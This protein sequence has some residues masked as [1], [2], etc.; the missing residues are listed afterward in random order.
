MRIVATGTTGGGAPAINALTETIDGYIEGRTLVGIKNE[1]GS[2]GVASE[3]PIPT[4]GYMGKD[5]FY[6]MSNDGDLINGWAIDAL[7]CLIYTGSKGRSARKESPICQIPWGNSEN[8]FFQMAHEVYPMGTIQGASVG[9][10]SRI[11]NGYH[12]LSKR[13]SDRGE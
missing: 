12:S 3:V 4:Y 6:H 1:P 11:V 13:Y 8:V 10:I 5:E 9:A 7:G 2:R